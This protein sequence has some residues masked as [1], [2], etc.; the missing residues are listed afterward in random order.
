MKLSTEN[1][2][3]HGHGEEICG[4][5]EEVVREWDGLEVCC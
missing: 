1:K 5:Q 2:Y 4:S 3:T